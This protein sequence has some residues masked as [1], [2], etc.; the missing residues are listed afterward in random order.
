MP[1]YLL[2][3]AVTLSVAIVWASIWALGWS[4]IAAIDE[5]MARRRLTEDYP[6]AQVEAVT[7]SKDRRA[8]LLWLGSEG[9]LVIA[10]GDRLALRKLGRARVAMAD[11]G[12]DIDLNDYAFPPVRALLDEPDRIAWY[13][14]LHA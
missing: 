6:E 3:P 11:D 13:E 4:E 9:V 2:V 8:A 1:L 7:L 10:V 5:P 12:L 14:R